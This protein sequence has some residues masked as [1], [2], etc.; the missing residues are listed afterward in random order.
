MVSS[1]GGRACVGVAFGAVLALLT[2]VA[3]ISGEEATSQGPSREQGGVTA[4]LLA[5]GPTSPFL[6]KLRALE[7]RYVETMRP[8]I[9]EPPESVAV[10]RLEVIFSARGLL[11]G[12]WGFG[13]A[14]PIDAGPRAD[15]R[16]PPAEAAARAFFDEWGEL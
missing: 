5:Q 9:D 13:M 11:R 6:R 4:S 7:R 8:G 3:C 16:E 12:A 1:T 14:I 2:A 15:R 10:G